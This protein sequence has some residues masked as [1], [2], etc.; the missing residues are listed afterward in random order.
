MGELRIFGSSCI[1]C[2]AR[3]LC[4]EI[5][6]SPAKLL[7]WPIMKLL[8]LVMF[9][10]AVLVAIVIDIAWI[11]STGIVQLHAWWKA[12]PYNPLERF[13]VMIVV[14]ISTGLGQLIIRIMTGKWETA[15]TKG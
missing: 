5:I 15:K 13:V 9:F 3:D 1:I 8:E 7:T 6:Y 2:A 11:I 4:D 10:T 14:A 12:Q